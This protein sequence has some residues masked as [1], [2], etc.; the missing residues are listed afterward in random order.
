MGAIEI[1]G[2]N[3]LL[4]RV[5]GGRAV[6]LALPRRG[7]DEAEGTTLCGRVWGGHA[8]E[9]A[10]PNCSRCLTSIDRLFPTP[11]PDARIGLVATLVV[12]ALR[13]HGYA[14]VVGVPGDQLPALRRTIRQQIRDALGFRCNTYVVNGRLLVASDEAYAPH[15]QRH[16]ETAA[17]A[18]NALFTGEEA[19]PVDDTEWRFHWSAWGVR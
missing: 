16:S 1:Q 17:A 14:E 9:E 18:M 5:G 8:D 6:H 3:Y 10:A 7:A 4:V 12:E 13:G 11:P 19:P 15:A 2:Q